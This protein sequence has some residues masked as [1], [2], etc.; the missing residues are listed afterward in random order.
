MAGQSFGAGVASPPAAASVAQSAFTSVFSDLDMSPSTR[1]N[2]IASAV[3]TLAQSTTVIFP[4]VISPP[5][6]VM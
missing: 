6:P 2:Q 3:H 4:P 1:A 5:S